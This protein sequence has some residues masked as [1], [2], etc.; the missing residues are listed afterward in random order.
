[1]QNK[2][3]KLVLMKLSEPGWDKE[4]SS[5]PELNQELGKYLCRDCQKEVIADCEDYGEGGTAED[6]MTYQ[7]STACGCEFWVEGDQE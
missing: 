4:F 3:T 7:L 2:F 1:M 5:Y 6:M